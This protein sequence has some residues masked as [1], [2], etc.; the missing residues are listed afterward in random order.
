MLKYCPLL[1]IRILSLE[2]PN[3]ILNIKLAGI[4]TKKKKGFEI[5]TYMNELHDIDNRF[6]ISG[7]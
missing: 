1:S 7:R 4:L 6:R 2:R 5:K 3:N